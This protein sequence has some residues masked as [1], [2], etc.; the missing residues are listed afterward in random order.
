MLIACGCPDFQTVCTNKWSSTYQW[1]QIFFSPTPVFTRFSCLS[2]SFFGENDASFVHPFLHG[3]LN[4]LLA[5]GAVLGP[6]GVGNDAPGPSPLF[7][8]HS[9]STEWAGNRWRKRSS[10]FSAVQ[11][12]LFP[13]K[14]ILVP[15]TWCWSSSGSIDLCRKSYR[16]RWC[17]F[18][19][20]PLGL[21]RR[22]PSC[23]PEWRTK[24]VVEK[25]PSWFRCIA[26]QKQDHYT[27]LDAI[28]TCFQMGLSVSLFYTKPPCFIAYQNCQLRVGLIELWQKI[29]LSFSFHTVIGL[30][31][32][33]F[34]DSFLFM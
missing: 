4:H 20:L 24:G 31:C 16:P 18:H 3:P 28:Y 22:I 23:I 30:N 25:G 5:S 29:W 2:R 33:H 32:N 6:D 21:T 10:G 14:L 7:I 27:R 19:P 17:H 34:I 12:C 11:H 15:V 13:F 1:W 9:C 8:R 26:T